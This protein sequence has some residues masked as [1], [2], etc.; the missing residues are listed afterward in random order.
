[1]GTLYVV[2]TPIGNL[3]DM[4][5]R[6]ITT[7]KEVSYILCEDTRT[8]LKLLDHFDIKNKLVSYHKF[9]EMEKVDKII[10]D[11]KNGMDVALIS[12]AGTPCI[13][14]PGNILVKRAREDGIKVLGVGGISALVTSLSVSGVN[15]DE[16]TFYGFFPRETKD[17]NKLI[18]EIESSFVN[19]FVFYESPKRIVKTLEFLSSKLGNVKV[20]VFKELTKIHEKN[21]YGLINDVILKLKEDEKTS[22]GEYTFIVEKEGRILEKN[23][24]SVE[25]LLVN[26]MIKE[27]ISLKDATNKLN[28]D[29]DDVSKKDIYNAGLN[30]KKL[31]KD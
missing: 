3:N 15:T 26:E 27:S 24:M 4:T 10:N 5:F 21:Y 16:F 22:L 9:N 6:A 31:F 23:E 8:S 29:L 25:A 7:L 19:T 13:S 20:S 11:L 30:L 17:K 12:D 28:N 18:K 14:D 1:M 2:A